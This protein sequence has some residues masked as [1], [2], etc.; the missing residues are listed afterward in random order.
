MNDTPLWLLLGTLV[1]LLSLSVIFS[2]SQMGM[3][4][5][6]RYR[7]KY[8]A[9]N[10]RG[11]RRL[12]KLL[13]HPDRLLGAIRA[14]NSLANNLA[15][16]VAAMIAARLYGQGSELV[17][18]VMFTIVVLAFAKA[19][20]GTI[21]AAHA[22]RIAAATSY[23][24]RPLSRLLYPMV[25]LV[26]HLS[27]GLLKLF[28][29][30]P[31]R[32]HSD[33]PDQDEPHAAADEPGNNSTVRQQRIL[34]NLLDLEQVTVNDIMVPRNEISGL[35]LEDNIASLV[36]RIVATEYTRLPLYKGDINNIVGVLH[37]RRVNRL[38]RRGEQALTLEAIKRFSKEPYFVPESTPL[39]MQLVNFQ[40][41]KR[42]IALVVDEYG[43]ILGLVT[44]E[45]ILE[46]IVGK[47]TTNYAENDQDILANP[48]R[49]YTIDAGVSIREINRATGWRLPTTGPKTLNGL[50]LEKLEHI[51]EG[52]VCLALA[53]YRFETLSLSDKMIDRVLVRHLP[54][55]D[56]DHSDDVDS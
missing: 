11:A 14:G 26:D 24:L 40:K 33:N 43:A 34:A 19:L 2:V 28:G 12:H 13:K 20:P 17:A 29:V 9:K 37:M 10:H 45:D 30:N 22:E 49:S 36:N 18:G 3:T 25:W 41:N 47:F 16:I 44:L 8:L 48:D 23:M 51:P 5:I 31:Q 56:T 54:G 39:H 35:D 55:L 1:L 32:P 53:S 42:R 50:L 21:G 27:N 46:E 6:D 52:N 15:A 4:S 7:L 38:L